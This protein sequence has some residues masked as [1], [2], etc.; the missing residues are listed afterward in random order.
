MNSSK[1][2]GEYDEDGNRITLGIPCYV[3]FQTPL[4]IEEYCVEYNIPLEAMDNTV[5]IA[6]MCNVDFTPKDK[7]GYMPDFPIPKG[8][9]ENT[10]LEKLAFEKFYSTIQAKNLKDDLQQRFKQLR[11][12][13]DVVIGSGFAGY[14]LIVSDF[15]KKCKERGIIVGPGRGSAAGSFL[16]YCLN[17]T[18]ID[19]L[20][21][22]FIFERFLNP[23]RVSMPDKQIA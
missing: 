2:I 16:S 6:K 20:P 19:P 7:K 18:N 17:I 15:V 22:G 23:E 10:Y 12:E 1:E 9:T 21:Y 4:E 5:K 13:L 3:H 8:Y 11:Y 14:F